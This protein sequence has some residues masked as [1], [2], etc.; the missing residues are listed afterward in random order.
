MLSEFGIGKMISQRG[1][2]HGDLRLWWHFSKEK[3]GKRIKVR[4]RW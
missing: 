4:G 3:Y 1:S 2:E